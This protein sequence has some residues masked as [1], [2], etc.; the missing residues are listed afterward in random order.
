MDETHA[1]PGQPMLANVFTLGVR[2]LGRQRD[3]YRR[4][5]LPQIVD[6]PDFA[7][8]ELRGAVLALFP[9]EKLAADGC[10]EPE[11]GQG[12]IRFTIGLIAGSASE[13][14]RLADR[15]RNLGGRT[16]KEPV[17]AEYFEGRSAYVA[18]PEGNFFEIA[19]AARA[20]NA[21]VA[22]AYRAAGLAPPT[23]A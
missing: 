11:P 10:A 2:D 19:W 22:A 20:D 14:D 18:D 4:L 15:F 8:F 1:A 16:S 21:I 7:A 9:V 17:D 6:E 3:F 12:G 13:V 5:D 23:N